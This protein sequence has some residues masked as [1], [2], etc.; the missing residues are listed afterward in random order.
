MAI[1]GVWAVVFAGVNG[2]GICGL[3]VKDG[4]FHGTDTAAVK[5]RGTVTEDKDTGKL[6]LTYEMDMPAGTWIVGGG[7]P[8]DVPSKRS[9]SFDLPPRFGELTAVDLPIL[10]GVKAIFKQMPGEYAP[11]ADANGLEVRP[12]P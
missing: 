1:D 12:R 8:M 3:V 11:F 4:A 5:Y 10:G 7:S 6:H 2:I 9:Y